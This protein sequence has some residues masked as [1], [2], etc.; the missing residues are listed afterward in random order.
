MSQRRQDPSSEPR[1]EFGR[2]GISGLVDWDRAV[3]AREVS[4]PSPEDVAR[5]ERVVDQLV[6]RARGRRRRP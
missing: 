4:Q 6:A 1:R 2:D 5:A 3:R